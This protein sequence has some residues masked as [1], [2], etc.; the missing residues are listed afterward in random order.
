[1]ETG[2]ADR[3]LTQTPGSIGVLLVGILKRPFRPLLSQKG[4]LSYSHKQILTTVGTTVVHPSY[5]G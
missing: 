5:F 4:E 2:V 1:M 3:V